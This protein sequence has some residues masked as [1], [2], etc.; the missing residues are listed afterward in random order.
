MKTG[1]LKWSKT[2]NDINIQGDDKLTECGK[3]LVFFQVLGTN[4][5][6]VSLFFVISLTDDITSH[7]APSAGK[8]DEPLSR[9]RSGVGLS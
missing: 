8:T 7:I 1:V 4:F 6:L 9:R 5:I 3:V 2:V